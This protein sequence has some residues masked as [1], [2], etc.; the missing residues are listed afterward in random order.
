MRGMTATGSANG[1]RAPGRVLRF[2]LRPPSGLGGEV[3]TA[4]APSA[5]AERV[6]VALPMALA[7]AQRVPNAHVITLAGGYCRGCGRL[8]PC[9]EREAAAEVF[10]RYGR[11][12][13]RRPGAS[14][15]ELVDARRVGGPGTLIAAAR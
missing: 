15:P 3:A 11:L 1:H 2:G 5:P 13:R 14:H 10:V 6:R 9:G 7:R 4:N 12:P 8:L